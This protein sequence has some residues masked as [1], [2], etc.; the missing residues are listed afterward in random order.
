MANQEGIQTLVK[1]NTD[2]FD[3]SD[4]KKDDNETIQ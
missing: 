1:E 2:K 3:A 4:L